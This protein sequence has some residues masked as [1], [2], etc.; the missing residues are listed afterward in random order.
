MKPRIRTRN[1][2]KKK[3][4]GILSLLE[5]LFLLKKDKDPTYWQLRG[6]R[7]KTCAYKR[8]ICPSERRI[9]KEK[10]ICCKDYEPGRR[11]NR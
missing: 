1:D 8:G 3:K 6:R 4:R 7:C 2:R 11:N 10:Y 9:V 5:K